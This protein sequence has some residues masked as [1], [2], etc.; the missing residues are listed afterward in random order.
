M[1]ALTVY[2][3]SRA[4]PPAVNFTDAKTGAT[5]AGGTYT[6]PNDGRTLLVA[7]DTGGA[8]CNVI[9]AIPTTVDGLAVTSKTIAT[10]IS[11]QVVIG[12]FPV[13][14]Y[15]TTVSFTVS[16]NT[17]VLAIALGE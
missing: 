1:P 9:I 17:D 6:F 2:T 8:G 11:K 10:G 14:V 13:S 16:A 5:A 3:T 15:S 7:A 12:P 4:T